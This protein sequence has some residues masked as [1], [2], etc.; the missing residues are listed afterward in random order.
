MHRL[1]ENNAYIYISIHIYIYIYIYIFQRLTAH[2]AHPVSYL[3]SQKLASLGVDTAS[4]FY[5]YIQIERVREIEIETR[6]PSL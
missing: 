1:C 3:C 2:A 6:I 4:R 5:I